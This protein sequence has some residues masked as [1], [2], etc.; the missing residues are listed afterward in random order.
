MKSPRNVW[1]FP[2]KT[3]WGVFLIAGTPKGLYRVCF[4]G[5]KSHFPRIKIKNQQIKNFIEYFKFPQKTFR[6][7]VDFSGYTFF[8]RKVLKMLLGVRPGKVISYGELARRA[9]YAGA[10]RAVGSVMRKNRLP[11]VL[12]CHRVIQQNGRLGRYSKGDHWKRRLLA[13]EGFFSA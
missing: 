5:E 11:L 7:K 13:H 10:A 8:E 9:G 1:S 4:P 3:K 6:M 2:V 12:P